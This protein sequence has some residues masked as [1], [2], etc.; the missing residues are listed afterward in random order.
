MEAYWAWQLI[1]AYQIIQPPLSIFSN[2]FFFYYRTLLSCFFQ[3][4]FADALC[5]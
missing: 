5:I 3:T 1:I 2:H 4:V